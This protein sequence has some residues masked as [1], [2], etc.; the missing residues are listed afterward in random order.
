LLRAFV[1]ETFR[2]PNRNMWPTLEQGDVLVASKFTF[3]LR[4]PGAAAPFSRGRL[5]ERGELVVL[6]TPGPQ[7]A[8]ARDLVR[9]VIALPGDTVAVQDGKV[10][11]N[12]S[13]LPVQGF[14]AGGCGTED[15]YGVCWEPPM[16]PALESFRVPEGQLF[17]L[18]DLR[19]SSVSELR[20]APYGRVSLTWLKAKVLGVWLSI[21]G[22]GGLSKMRWN[23]LWKGVN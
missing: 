23:R 2:M 16:L 14:Q 18:P 7:G 20:Q 6:S 1:I 19:T 13:A 11:L 3:G 5:P 10:I 9:R 15:R 17:V 8:G 21:D 4:I 22:S 12:G